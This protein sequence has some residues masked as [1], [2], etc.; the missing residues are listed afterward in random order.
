M[1][2]EVLFVDEELHVQAV[3]PGVRV[4]VDVPQIVP[5]PVRAIITE[6]DGVPA[7]RALALA[8][9]AST[10]DPPRGKRQP[11]ELRQELGREER[12]ALAGPHVYRS[13]S[14]WK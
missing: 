12:G 6:L 9:H 10:E 3:E 13:S 4:P 2:A 7:A 1:E 8:L 14:A 5:H 11:L